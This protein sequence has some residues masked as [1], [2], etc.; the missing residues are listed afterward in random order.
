MN[1]YVPS[2]HYKDVTARA[3]ERE[4]HIP[5]RGNYSLENFSLQADHGAML[6]L[7]LTAGCEVVISGDMTSS[8]ANGNIR[9]LSNGSDKWILAGANDQ[10][11][12]LSL[13]HGFHFLGTLV[14]AKT[15][16]DVS[17]TSPLAVIKYCMPDG[18][19]LAPL[20]NMT[21]LSEI[22]LQ[23]KLYFAPS[24]S[25]DSSS[26]EGI[27]LENG[28]IHSGNT[29]VFLG[30]IM[31]Q[32][33]VSL[34]PDLIEEL[35]LD[36]HMMNPVAPSLHP[37]RTVIVYRERLSVLDCFSCGWQTNEYLL[38]EEAKYNF[39]FDSGLSET[40]RFF[41]PGLYYVQFGI[42]LFGRKALIPIRYEIMCERR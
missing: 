30:K 16:G 14:N 13:E 23:G 32:N 37:P 9:I 25:L 18:T 26:Q 33:G 28:K 15:E 17:I 11:I 27:R 19:R 12:D 41:A 36:C 2:L 1:G 39:R 31:D 24:G 4:S 38:D 35:T 22:F 42:K 34:N 5:M 3:F 21:V 20:P 40:L 29:A 6:T 7:D 10:E 8:N